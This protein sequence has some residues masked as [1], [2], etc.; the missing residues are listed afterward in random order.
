MPA[1]FPDLAAPVPHSR[2]S[3]NLLTLISIAAAAASLIGLAR[4]IL[5]HAIAASLADSDWLRSSPI[6]AQINT[7]ARLAGACGTLATLIMGGIA[8]LLVRIDKRFTSGWYFL[9]IF[10]CISLMSSGR[11]LYSAITGAGDWSAI[12][13]NFNPPWLWRAALA[14][15]GAFIYRPALVFAVNALRDLIVR[16]EVDYRDLSR[17]VFPAYL[18]A[19]ILLTAGAALHP[20]KEGPLEIGL[21]AAPF[22]LNLGLL[23]VP[24]FISQPVESETIVARPLPF[25]WLWVTIGFAATLAYL[26]GLGPVMRLWM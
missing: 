1:T 12:I 25:Y 4:A 11:L 26:A 21:V 22:A 18:T 23:V 8:A 13:A 16:S 24:L 15:T 14:A 2:S 3:P 5:G 10:G 9:W 17:L 7:P 20:L 6:L 19:S